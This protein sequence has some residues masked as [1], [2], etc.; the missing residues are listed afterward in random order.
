MTIK[1]LAA[2]VHGRLMDRARKDGRPFQEL[3]EYFAMERFLYRLSSSAHGDR[4]VLKGALMLRVWDAPAARP[5]RDIDLLGRMDNSPEH[6]AQVIAEVC[7]AEVEPDGLVFKASTVKAT[8]IGY[9]TLL[10]F[11][12][13]RMKGYP[14]ETVVAEKFEAMVKL[15]TLNSRMKD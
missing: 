2:S 14:R 1:N 12:A 4:F 9:P 6:L 15:G 8:K 10:D 5:T 7:D 11:P 3:L 13:P